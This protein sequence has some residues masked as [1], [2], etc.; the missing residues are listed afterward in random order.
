MKR[1]LCVLLAVVLLS[2]VAV[3]VSAE[4]GNVRYAGDAGDFIFEPGGLD[5]PTDLFPNFK[6]V[7]PGDTITQRIAVK[8]EASNEVKVKIYMRA[9]GAND[10]QSEAFLAQLKM[11]VT[12]E[13]DTVM[14]DA[15]PSEKA[16]LEEWAL[17]GTLYSGGETELSVT[18]TV[19]TELGNDA[20]YQKGF[21]DWEFKV[22]EF[23]VEPGDPGTG[24][25]SH[26]FLWITVSALSGVGFVW[27]I[28]VLY[29]RK[30]KEKQAN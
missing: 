25:R 16:G 29:R 1:I 14:F 8:N 5:S 24:D 2:S 4:D 17:L 9:L 30:K 22:E 18:L 3:T 6:D 13:E 12:K 23:P 21:L 11:K 15:A 28:A 27:L 26:P 7:M 19:P 10:P 20:A